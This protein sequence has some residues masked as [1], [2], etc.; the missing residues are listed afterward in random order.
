MAGER[1]V[2]LLGAGSSYDC[3][4]TERNPVDAGWRPPL[5]N[6]LFDARATFDEILNRYPG[7]RARADQIRTAVQKQKPFEELLRDMVAGPT[8][9]L[10]RGMWEVPLYLQELM[11]E[12]ST[13]YVLAGSTKFETMLTMVMASSFRQI[14]ILTVNYDLF[15]ERAAIAL[16]RH[17]FDSVDKYI[18]T[19]D[20]QRWALIKLHGSVNWGRRFKPS[21]SENYWGSIFATLTELVLEDEVKVLAGHNSDHR[22]I[23]PVHY[24]PALALPVAGKTDFVCPPSHV[25]YARG[26]LA[27]LGGPDRLVIIGFSGLDNHVLQSLLANVRC[28][29][30]L[31]IVNGDTKAGGATLDRIAR[32]ARGVGSA[33]SPVYDGGFRK[34]IE[35]GDFESFLR[36]DGPP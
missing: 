16:M 5:V 1:L 15:V 3:V 12:V 9:A 2:I 26:F 30:M 20:E 13:R 17:A 36:E 35:S 7:A 21:R 31:R 33:H 28:V 29:P 14:L 6:Q 4:D 32:A 22:F 27:E 24:Y 10:R 25:D 18:W 34:F 19:C 23:Q 8:L 11:G